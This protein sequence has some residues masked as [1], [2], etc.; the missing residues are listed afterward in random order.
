MPA[1]EIGAL[2][3]A[4]LLAGAMNAIAGGGMLIVFPTLLAFGV[5]AIRANATC[6]LALFAG[7]IG[8]T[9]AYRAHLPSTWPWVRKFG[10]VSVLGGW[11]GALLLTWTPN[12][13]FEKLVPFLLLFATIVFTA[14][15]FFRRVAAAEAVAVAHGARFGIAAVGFQ[16]LLAIYGGYFGAGIG[17]LMLAVFGLMGFHHIHE[18]NALKTILAV[19]IN[20]VATGYFIHTGL[21]EWS[22]ALIMTAGAAAGYFSGARFTQR[23][24]QRAV[25]QIIT[26]IG[27]GISAVLFWK[28]FLA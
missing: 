5:P 8:S 16:F 2:F 21:I 17:I 9:Y 23:I 22:P 12:E 28:Q 26:A 20:A 13:T 24:P 1:W 18:M 15:T 7:I 4:A 25:R 19:L 27:L 11:L 10:L 14:Q 3:G 6:T